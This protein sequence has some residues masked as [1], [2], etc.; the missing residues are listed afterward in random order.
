MLHDLELVV[1]VGI[2]VHVDDD[3]ILDS[4]VLCPLLSSLF[5]LEA[6]EPFLTKSW[7]LERSRPTSPEIP[8]L[9]M[10]AHMTSL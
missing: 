2:R 9:D 6:L 3:R 8:F 4:L 5:G 10:V 1:R 7:Q